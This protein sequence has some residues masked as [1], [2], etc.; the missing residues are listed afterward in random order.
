MS[1]QE[2]S[3]PLKNPTD[4]SQ[5]EIIEWLH[6]T[7]NGHLSDLVKPFIEHKISGISFATL[8]QQELQKELN[9]KEYGLVKE[10]L[11]QRDR[12]LSFYKQYHQSQ[13]S[14]APSS[15]PSDMGMEHFSASKSIS[16]LPRINQ[17][18]WSKSTKHG[19]VSPQYKS[20]VHDHI[21]DERSG[22]LFDGD[23]PINQT[24]MYRPKKAPSLQIS[25]YDLSADYHSIR[26]WNECI[27]HREDT[28]QTNRDLYEDTKIPI[29]RTDTTEYVQQNVGD[30]LGPND[31]S[32][33]DNG[34]TFFNEN[35]YYLN[36]DD[37]GKSAGNTNN[38]NSFDLLQIDVTR[39]SQ[40]E[41]HDEMNNEVNDMT[42]ILITTKS[43]SQNERTEDIER[44]TS[45][46][47][48]GI[49]SPYT[50]TITAPDQSP[51]CPKSPNTRQKLLAAH[52]QSAHGWKGVMST[53]NKVTLKWKPISSRPIAIGEAPISSSLL[54]RPSSDVDNCENADESVVY[55]P[56]IY[57]YDFM[58]QYADVSYIGGRH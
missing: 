45:K 18:E 12:M 27:F 7:S 26:E 49:R 3:L 36:D 5:R 39:I 24:V 11:I 28:V 2:S 13:Q 14:E 56:G 53:D 58:E 44:S 52:T 20:P 15:T 38:S 9:I 19:V 48:G 31:D 32:D 55:A 10:F 21:V 57:D 22:S 43:I 41:N 47:L 30:L 54:S 4:W 6:L 16:A 17:I 37:Q 46:T 51:S 25:R 50:M 29:V 8:S 42:R 35:E 40:N 23:L 33:D 1:F 34:I